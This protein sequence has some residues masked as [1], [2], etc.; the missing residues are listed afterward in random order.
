MENNQELL[1]DPV[2]NTV[3]YQKIANELESELFKLMQHVECKM[4]RSYKYWSLK[5][6]ILKQKYNIDWKSPPE[7][8]PGIIFN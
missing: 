2:E 3:E 5:K 8:N 7:M 6:R 1:Y 4:G